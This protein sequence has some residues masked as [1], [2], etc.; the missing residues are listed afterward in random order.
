MTL[1]TFPQSPRDQTFVQ[2]PYPVYKQMRALGPLFDWPDYGMVAAA[3]HATIDAL[4]RDRRF[5]RE[6]P[7]GIDAPP[8]LKPFYDLETNS[9]L[10][11]EPPVH[12][13][14]R[15]LVLRAFTSRRINGLAP[16]IAALSHQLIDDMGANV[17][18]LP[19]FAERLPVIIIARLLGV[20]E[21][22]ADQLLIW[23][24]DMVAM[25]QSR[26]DRAIEDRAIAAVNAFTAFLHDIIAARRK[27]PQ[28]DLISELIAARD[29]HDRLTEAELISTCILLL[30]AG[31]EATVHTIGNGIKALLEAGPEAIAV[32]RT[33]PG[34]VAEEILR[35]DPPLHVFQRIAQQDVEVFGHCFQT[36]DRV[37]LILGSAGRDPAVVDAPDR[38]DPTRIKPQHLAFGGGLHFCVGAPLARLELAVALPILFARHPALC[39]ADETE[40]A[41]R[42]HFHAL[43]ALSVNLCG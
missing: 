13:R 24:H 40:Y 38:F 12:T 30:N 11:R 28:D 31:H 33:N 1:P 27:A 41:D 23:S 36:G 15:G 37:A 6:V 32:L 39:L 8:H 29:D 14:L 7:G 4:L 18:L 22:H 16:E 5:G 34:A 20:P 26:R 2:N 19:T 17:D 21:D 3:N 35:F 43:T 42:Y 25:Y 10:E 9:M